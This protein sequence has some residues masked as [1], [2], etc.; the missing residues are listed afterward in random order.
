MWFHMEQVLR[1]FELLN[2]S[3]NLLL[4]VTP[5]SLGIE[6]MGGLMEKIIPRNSNIPIVKEQVF[7][8]NE[9]GQTSIKISV[10][11]GE[12]EISKNNTFLGELILSNLE[13]K[14]A[15]IPRVR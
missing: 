13:P 3:N 12:R 8:T 11:Q 2:G 6:T 7:T 1:A 9:N 14:P 4:D 15:G 10:L 5:L